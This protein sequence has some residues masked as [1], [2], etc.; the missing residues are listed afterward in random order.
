MRK[1]AQR[2]IGWTIL[3]RSGLRRVNAEGVQSGVVG[4]SVTAVIAH[5]ANEGASGVISVAIGLH[6]WRSSSS[7]FWGRRCARWG[8]LEEK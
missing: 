7:A 2:P 1:R 8:G 6:P 5:T 3:S 4:A